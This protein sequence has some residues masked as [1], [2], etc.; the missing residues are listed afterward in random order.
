M[1]LEEYAKAMHALAVGPW[2][3]HGNDG[4]RIAWC[5]E[6]CREYLREGLENVIEKDLRRQ[7][8]GNPT[9]LEVSLLPKPE[10]VSLLVSA[11]QE[12]RLRL[13]DVGSCYNP[14]EQYQ[15][16][17][18]TPI[19]ISPAVEVK[20]FLLEIFYCYLLFSECHPV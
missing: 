18:V 8:H 14:F 19:D 12:R 10:E 20:Q 13:L 17:D 7:A 2:S 3:K 6:S 15:E 9:Q 4:G 5:V 1:Q 16:F 11:F